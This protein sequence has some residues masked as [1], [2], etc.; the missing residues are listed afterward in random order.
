[1]IPSFDVT[2]SQR[3]HYLLHFTPNEDELN[4]LEKNCSRSC[5]LKSII[6]LYFYDY[7]P[8][9]KGFSTKHCELYSY[10]NHA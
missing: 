9:E 8:N 7:I 3:L 4:R 2:E 10:R 5:F 1:M 6:F